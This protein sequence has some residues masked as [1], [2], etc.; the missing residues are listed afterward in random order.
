MNI[1][2]KKLFRIF[3]ILI[4][5]IMMLVFCSKEQLNNLLHQINSNLCLLIKNLKYNYGFN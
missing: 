3:T 1:K 2:T 4:I 5:T